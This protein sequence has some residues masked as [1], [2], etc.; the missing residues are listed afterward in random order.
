M[1]VTHNEQQR[2]TTN[3]VVRHLVPDVGELG[4]GGMGGAYHGVVLSFCWRH[5]TWFLLLDTGG[6]RGVGSRFCA[7]GRPFVFVLGRMSLFGR[8]SS[9]S[10]H[11]DDDEQQIRICCSSSGRHV[12]VSDVA[13]GMCVSK[14]R[15]R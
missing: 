14:E 9:L 3:V 13:P 1:V 5:G 15:G 7:C 4:W 12:A 11:L 8:S 2:M 10:G 6:F